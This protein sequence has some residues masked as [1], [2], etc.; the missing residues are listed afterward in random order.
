VVD[1]V[2]VPVGQRGHDH[3]DPGE[4][5]EEVPGALVPLAMMAAMVE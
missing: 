3:G 1:L 5:Q 2:G 4:R